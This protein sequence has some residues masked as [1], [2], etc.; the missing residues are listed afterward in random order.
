MALACV[1][2]WLAIYFFVCFVKEMK[3]VFQFC[4]GV[5]FQSSGADREQL[6]KV[7]TRGRKRTFL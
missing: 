4:D 5:I 3:E 7:K 6:R 1:H 2:A